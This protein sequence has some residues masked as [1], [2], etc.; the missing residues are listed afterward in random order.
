[1]SSETLTT[2]CPST[3]QP[4]VTRKAA[5]SEEI[6]KLPSIAQKAFAAYRKSYPT[7]NSRQKIVTKALQ[8]IN[9]KQDVLPG[10]N[11]ST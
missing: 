7:L 6:A 2:I 1:M 8:L 4:I 10:H 3:N 11:H 5:S 9:E